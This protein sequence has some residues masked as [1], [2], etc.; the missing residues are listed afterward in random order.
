MIRPREILRLLYINRVLARH[1]LDEIIL[2]THLFRPVRFVYYLNPWNWFRRHELPR[3]VRIRLALQ[4]LGPIFVK[5]GQ[6][7]STRR[8][9]IPTDIADELALLQDKVAPFPT[10]QALVIIERS[11]GRPLKQI[12]A[13]FDETPLASASVAQVYAAELDGGQRVVVK[14][15]R[16][17]IRAVINRDLALMGLLAR[18][19]ERY[20]AEARRLRPLEI[21]ADYQ[22]TILDELDLVREAANASQLR[23]NFEGSDLIYVP[24]VHWQWTTPQVMVME[25]ISGVR[26]DNIEELQARGVNMKKLA[27]RGVEI[28]FKQVFVDNFFHADMHPGNIFVSTQDPENPCY[29]AVDFGIVG[30]L[31]DGDKHYLAENFLAFFNRD[32]RRVAQLHVDS[33]WVPDSVRIED[34]EAAIRAVCE[35]NFE[36]PLKEISFGNVLVRL[37]QVVRRFDFVIQPQLILLQKTLLNIEGLGRRLYPDLDLWKTAKPFL[38]RAMRQE[39]LFESLL[40]KLPGRKPEWLRRLPDWPEYIDRI[41]RDA[42]AGRLKFRLESEQL[43]HLERRLRDNGRRSFGATVGSALLISAAVVLATGAAPA[44]WFWGVPYESWVLGIA[45]AFILIVSGRTT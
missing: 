10:E 20:S 35:P 22:K 30:A 7:V 1:G 5:L 42:A 17:N 32:Y 2:A 11:L 33:G 39:V 18:L 26:V 24:R 40:D 3:G 44:Q 28:F 16:P 23:R 45:G 14:V 38:Q 15:I 31:S 8:D 34:L 12:F 6:L 21:V 41:L 9:L 36:R 19:A 27:E 4:D 37:F 29:I 13:V 43:E 25:R